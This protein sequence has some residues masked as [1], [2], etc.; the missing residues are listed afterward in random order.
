MFRLPGARSERCAKPGRKVDARSASE[1]G[2]SSRGAV[3]AREG[4]EVKVPLVEPFTPPVLRDVA[5]DVMDAE[6]ARG[7]P[8]EMAQLLALLRESTVARTPLSSRAPH[9]AGRFAGRAPSDRLAGTR[10]GQWSP[11][12]P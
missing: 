6:L 11:C 8:D 12:L 9:R 5:Q 7:D 10:A 3:L 2:R 1:R 4:F